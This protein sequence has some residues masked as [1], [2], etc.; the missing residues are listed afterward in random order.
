MTSHPTSSHADPARI[1]MHLADA[2]ARQGRHERALKHYEKAL[3]IN[4]EFVPVLLRLGDLMLERGQA[5]EGLDYLERAALVNVNDTEVVEHFMAARNGWHTRSASVKNVDSTGTVAT[6][7]ADHTNGKLDLGRQKTFVCHRSGWNYA[8]AALQPLHRH[9]GVLFDGFVEDTFAWQHWRDG[10]RDEATL[11]QWRRQGTLERLA[12]SEELGIT[13]YK[14]PW[15]GCVHNP[16]N[17]PAWFHPQEAPQTV[18]AK[19]IW[20]QSLEACI[21]LFA[22]SE[23]QARWLAEQTQKPVSALTLP[24]EIPERQ[25]DFE[26]FLANADKKIIQVGW[27]MRKLSAIYRLPLA[28]GNPL[29]YEKMR[30]VPHFSTN[31]DEYL[32]GLMLREIELY[33][34]AIEPRFAE[35]TFERQHVT[36]L[37]YDALLGENLAFVELYDASANNL[38]V[39]CIARA[40]PL[41]INPL[42]AVVEYLGAEYPLYFGDLAEAAEKALDVG[43][44]QRT[45]E[46]L[47]NCGTRRKLSADYFRESVLQSEVYQLL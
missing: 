20:Q 22:L 30:L 37:E 2:W 44:L 5:R 38:V 14:R 25:F 35:N 7:G 19:K 46:Y 34:L 18:F 29:S 45:H 39:E 42:P 31:S 11:D 1:H 4:P 43:L 17:M 10:I 9:G 16:P 21:G 33:G 6:L 23:Y 3:E 28:R 24:T 47:Q 12:T 8:L 32:K 27:W 15:V 40:T 36:A 41:L 13:P 26:R